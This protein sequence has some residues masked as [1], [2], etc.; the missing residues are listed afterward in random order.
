MSLP[1]LDAQLR[2]ADP[3]RWAMTRLAPPATRARLVTLYTLDAELARAAHASAEPLLTQIRLQ[4]WADT[5]A[6]G[7]QETPLLAAIAEVWAS[8]AGS[9]VPLAEGWAAEGFRLDQIDATSGEVMWQA[10]RLLGA[11]AGAEAA[12]RA[13]GR[14][15]GI[16]A[17]LRPGPP[18][19]DLAEAG[20]AGF[21]AAGGTSLPAAV[22]PALWAGAD[23]GRVLA[24]CLGGRNPG[25]ISEFARRFALARFALTGNWRV[26]VRA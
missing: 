13:Q 15:A 3:E 2:A 21:A 9:L 1:D 17:A 4:W 24:A 20:R 10:A 19:V 16:V 14:G 5:L 18:D 8:A 12:V 25:A 11:G 6:R 22:A 23:A 26:A 7:G